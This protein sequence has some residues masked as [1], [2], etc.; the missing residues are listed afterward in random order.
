MQAGCDEGVKV[1][2]VGGMQVA[3]GSDTCLE[4]REARRADPVDHRVDV[5]LLADERP[6]VDLLWNEKETEAGKKAGV[7]AAQKIFA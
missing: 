7:M 3:A 6:G 2:N 5:E 1:R 4:S